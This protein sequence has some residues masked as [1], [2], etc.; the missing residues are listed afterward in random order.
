MSRSDSA[1]SSA[2]QS[3]KLSWKALI[4]GRGLAPSGWG[5]APVAL[6]FM[7]LGRIASSSACPVSWATTS[8]LAPEN[9][10]FPV[11]LCSKTRDPA[12]R[13]RR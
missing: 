2:M 5:L 10:V 8:V 7:R 12:G 6:L 3:P 13:S 9:V 11:T 4:S 1:V